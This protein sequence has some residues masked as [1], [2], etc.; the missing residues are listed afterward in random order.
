M[1]ITCINTVNHLNNYFLSL[2]NTVEQY[3]L[4]NT[5]QYIVIYKAFLHSFLKL[6]FDDVKVSKLIIL[7]KSK[8]FNR[9]VVEIL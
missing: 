8:C 3:L 4:M 2:T 7:Y 6:T 1:F 5:K 9:G